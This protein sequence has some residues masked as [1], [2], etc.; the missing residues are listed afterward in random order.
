MIFRAIPTSCRTPRGDLKVVSESYGHRMGDAQINV[1]PV[2][3]PCVPG[4]DC[5]VGQVARQV[6]LWWL[7]T[8]QRQARMLGL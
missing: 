1:G 5:R 8:V 2:S 4:C 6:G 7:I 3:L